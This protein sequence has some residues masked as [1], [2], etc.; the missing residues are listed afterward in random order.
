LP[1]PDIDRAKQAVR[2]R[3]WAL[4]ERE[5]ATPPGVH[6]C[7]PAFVGADVA[8]E[9]L[10]DLPVWQA[11][12]VVKSNPDTAQWPV[13]VRALSSGKLLYMAVP[14]L[15][16]PKPFYLLDSGEPPEVAATAS[17][18][19]KTAPTVSPDEMRPVD[20]VVTGSVAVNRN[21]VRVGKGAG[22]ADLEVAMLI[23]ARLIGPNTAIVTTVH[24]LQVI[25]EEL[26]EAE[27]DFTVDLIVT[28]DEVIPCGPPRRPRGIMPE[29][30]KPEQ[31]AAIPALAKRLQ[32]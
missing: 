13:R 19:A 15:A 5:G 32:M 7:I 23:E 11:A 6:G 14:R 20:L 18:A 21:G 27:Y 30:V 9:R 10:V 29:Q 26:P 24:P 25:D 17:D 31:I 1:V 12:Q 22:Y 28:P 3:M 8:A 2:E 16:T 4:L